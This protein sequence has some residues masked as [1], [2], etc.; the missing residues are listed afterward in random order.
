MDLRC[1]INGYSSIVWFFMFVLF[2]SICSF[3]PHTHQLTGVLAHERADLL[4]RAHQHNHTAPH[5]A[6]ACRNAPCGSLFFFFSIFLF[7]FLFNPFCVLFFLHILFYYPP[8]VILVL[9]L[10]PNIF[11]L[12][13]LSHL[14]CVFSLALSVQHAP[15]S[16]SFAFLLSFHLWLRSFFFLFLLSPFLALSFVFSFAFPLP[17]VSASNP[18]WHPLAQAWNSSGSFQGLQCGLRHVCSVS[19]VPRCEIKHR[20]SVTHW[21]CRQNLR[22]GGRCAPARFSSR[23]FRTACARSW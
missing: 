4:N 15:F 12:L 19:S 23:P 22:K 11:L 5:C 21:P 20:R 17:S 9:L 3:S 6:T 7:L 8:F 10:F 2:F 14:F 18:F 16:F 1:L 13:R